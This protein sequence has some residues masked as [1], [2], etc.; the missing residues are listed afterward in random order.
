MCRNRL[1]NW[2]ARAR[3]FSIVSAIF[4]L[5]VLATLGT[6][7]L[8]FS[9]SQHAGSAQDIQ[10][11]RAYHA[12]K[13][14]IEWG[15]YQ[16]LQTKPSQCASSTTLTPGGTLSGFSVTVTCLA[17][18]NTLN[19]AGVIHTNYTITSTAVLSSNPGVGSQDYVE[20]KLTVTVEN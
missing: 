14:G 9:T 3:G 20:R 19:E 6:L 15:L 4:L 5:V 1:P 18:S 2:P 10:G 12:A 17:D 13:A 7:M 16:L 8:T 11:S